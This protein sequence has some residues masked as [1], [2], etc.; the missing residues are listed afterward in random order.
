MANVKQI[1]EN[2]LIENGYSGLWCEECG[3]E[4][5]DLMPCCGADASGIDICKAGYKIYCTGE[6]ADCSRNDYCDMEPEF[7]NW[8]ISGE[9]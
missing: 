4:I 9:K 7:W 3:C 8:Y 1:L 2:W 6:C 5:D